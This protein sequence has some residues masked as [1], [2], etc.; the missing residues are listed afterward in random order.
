V[1]REVSIAARERLKLQ[2]DRHV[3]SP[4]V[5]VATR[6]VVPACLDVEPACLFLAIVRRSLDS[7]PQSLAIACR[8]R[9][10]ASRGVDLA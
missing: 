3:A 8:D 2:R 6:G 7:V 4:G 1:R 5:D 10:F 9:D